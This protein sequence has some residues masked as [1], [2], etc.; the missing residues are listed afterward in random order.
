MKLADQS[1]RDKLYASCRDAGKLVMKY[2]PPFEKVRDHMTGG[3]AS[4]SDTELQNVI[5]ALLIGIEVDETW[6]LQR[7]PD[8]AEAMKA[9]IVESARRH[10]INDGYFEGRRP[11]PIVVDEAWYLAQYPEVAD[12]VRAGVLESAQQH[13]DD[14]GYEEGRLPW[15]L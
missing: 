9:G 10:F 4:A 15:Q 12:A 5:R 3:A 14:H 11:F 8:I 6:Y 1:C 7:N 13:F 2:L